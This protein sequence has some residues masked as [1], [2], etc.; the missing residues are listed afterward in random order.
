MPN[1][2]INFYETVSIALLD[3]NLGEDKLVLV[4]FFK[5][6]LLSIQQMQTLHPFA[7]GDSSS[8]DEKGKFNEFIEKLD[9]VFFVFSLLSSFFLLPFQHQIPPPPYSCVVG[10]LLFLVNEIVNS[11]FCSVNV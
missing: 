10:Y 7:I 9:K 1:Y 6:E 4:T 2:I 5:F 8:Q 3:G 11:E